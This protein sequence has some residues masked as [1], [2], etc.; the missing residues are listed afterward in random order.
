MSLLVVDANVIV[1]ACIDATGLGP[2]AGHELVGPPVLRPEALSSLH[3]L[4]IRGEISAELAKAA[5][6]RLATLP[7]TIREPQD[8]VQSAWTIAEALGWAKTYD[9]EYVAL[10]Q[11]LDCRLVTL[12]ARLAR[13]A[14]R[15]ATIVGPAEL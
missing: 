5:V 12:D 13:G 11:L 9:A 2:L 10:A 1:Q 6:D 15:L 7:F 14:A 8:L 3:E 4:R